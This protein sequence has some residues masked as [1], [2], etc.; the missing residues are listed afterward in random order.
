IGKT[1]FDLIGERDI[2]RSRETNFTQ[3]ITDAI[4]WK[5]ESDV[6]LINGGSIRDSIKAGDIR[7]G[8]IVKAIPFGN[9]IVTKM[10]SGEDLIK[11]LENGLKAIPNSLGGMAQVA[12]VEVVFDINKEPLNRI[13]SV[14]QN[15]VPIYLENYYNVAMTDFMAL[16][17]EEYSSFVSAKELKNY[18][19]VEDIVIEYI[20]KFGVTMGDSIV[21]RLISKN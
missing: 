18:P 8:D 11:A 2:V 3:L 16:G 4:L 20:K 21:S 17:G 1:N 14:F 19:V 9:Y 15:K 7:I 10:I 5:T 12:G 13:E 6:V